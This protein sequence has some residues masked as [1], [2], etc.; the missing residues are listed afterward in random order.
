MLRRGRGLRLVPLVLLGGDSRW[1]LIEALEQAP[2]GFT[3]MKELA[4][5]AGISQTHFDRIKKG[6][7]DWDGEVA[8][9]N[10]RRQQANAA[11]HQRNLPPVPRLA[12][13]AET[14]VRQ[15]LEDYPSDQM[16]AP[17]IA[18]L[19][20]LAV[21]PTIG[22]HAGLIAAHNAALAAGLEE[23]AGTTIRRIIEGWRPASG[24][25]PRVVVLSP[26]L[27][28]ALKAP[29]QTLGAFWRQDQTG[30]FT[31]LLRE[32]L[33]LV[34]TDPDFTSP[35]SVVSTPG[36][37]VAASSGRGIVYIGQTT[38]DDRDERGTA[39]TL[40]RVGQF[41]SDNTPANQVLASLLYEIAGAAGL[42]TPHEQIPARLD[43][44][45]Q[46][47]AALLAGPV[48]GPQLRPIDE[49]A[50]ELGLQPDEVVRYGD[51]IK[52][53]AERVLKRLAGQP[54]GEVVPILGITS[55]GAVR[56]CTEA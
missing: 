52:F 3:L 46:L 8:A 4:G 28:Q 36:A 39:P 7:L 55:E 9:A 6:N 24:T 40:R 16:T 44:S 23:P 26:L 33:L 30:A 56:T 45:K 19:T 43:E 42:T 15:A 18:A 48:W 47:A 12:F 25:S 54:I 51:V 34:S 20:R 11:R 13:D 50:R 41:H 35:F 32:R 2:G 22:L 14:A 27:T 1:N 38:L 5:P 21:R 53:D 17:R 10:E 31:A 49:V 37:A 29:L